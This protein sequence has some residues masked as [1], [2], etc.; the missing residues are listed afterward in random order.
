MENKKDVTAI[1][2]MVGELST[3]Q[4]EL[5]HEEKSYFILENNNPKVFVNL[6]AAKNAALKKGATIG[7]IS[8]DSTYDEF[9]NDYDGKAKD[10]VAELMPTPLKQ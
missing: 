2:H 3:V 8:L 6:E 5:R 4:V 1:F 9:A 10:H 7:Y